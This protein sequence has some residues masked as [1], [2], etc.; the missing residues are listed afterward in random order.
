MFSQENKKFAEEFLGR[1]TEKLYVMA[2]EIGANF[3]YSGE[4][5]W[6]P[7]GEGVDI[8]DWQMGFWPGILW[9]MY[10]NTGDEMFRKYAEG[11]E[12]KLDEAFDLFMGLHHDT[13]FMW[14][15]SA[16]AD[17]KLTGNARSRE[18]AL[19]AA[20]LLAGR[21]N[22]NGRFIRAWNVPP[23]GRAIIDCMMNIPILTWASDEI[24]D[25]RFALIA[26]AHADTSMNHF[27]RCDG[28]V[29]HKVDFDPITGEVLET[30]GGQGYGPG[31]SWSRG[32]AWA[33][34]GFVQAYLNLGKKEYLECAKRVTH[35]FIANI[36]K[37][38]IPLLDFRA[39]KEPRLFDA[40]AGAVAA[41]GLIE[42]AKLVPEY[43]VE[44]YE[45]AAMSLLRGLDKD[46]NYDKNELNLLSTSSSRY[47]TTIGHHA[48]FIYGDY[49]LVE[50][51]MKL[52]G[53]DGRFT[54]HR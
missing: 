6:L 10:I 45:N 1:V 32:Q 39:P 18:R 27:I 12:E 43:E 3:P 17:F 35:Y 16:V 20:T 54:I 41:C 22:I 36:E 49:Y 15:L 34:Y 8:T 31:S 14:N 48:P 51:L 26:E 47:H 50:A 44:I 5:G 38:S 21:Y 29:H 19:H 13:G 37:D 7:K 25:P 24:D 40:S 53:N 2:K 42:I 4:N 46:C 23:N 33:I 9:L 28:S 30:P 52:H 11:C